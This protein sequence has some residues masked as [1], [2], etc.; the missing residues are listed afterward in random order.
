MRSKLSMEPETSVE[1]AAAVGAITLSSWDR[2][3]GMGAL[4]RKRRPECKG[5]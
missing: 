1:I 4:H 5:I 2:L 3:E